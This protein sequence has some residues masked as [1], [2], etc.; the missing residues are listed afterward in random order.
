[1]TTSNTAGRSIL[2]RTLSLLGKWT[3][4]YWFA[5]LVHS[6]NISVCFNLILA[7]LMK[8]ALD[9]AQTGDIAFL[10]HS[11]LLAGITFVGGTPLLMFTN[12]TGARSLL[13]TLTALR[14][15]LFR[16]TMHLPVAQV[17]RQHSGDLISRFSNDLDTLEGLFRNGIS[18]LSM[19]IVIGTIGTVMVFSL[20]WRLGL[21]SLIL[22]ALTTLNS[23][24]FTRPLRERTDQIQAVLGKLTE[25][26]SD[27]I[28]SLTVTKLFQLETIILQQYRQTNHAFVESELAQARLD[29]LHQASLKLLTWLRR[30]GTLA[31][32]LVMISMDQ[33]ELG[34]LWAIIHLQG[35]ASFMFSNIGQFLTGIQRSLSG[36]TRLFDLLD[37]PVELDPPDALPLLPARSSE[38]ALQ[39]E[40]LCFEYGAHS[41]N[42]NTLTLD[43]LSFT[44]SAGDMVALVGPSGGGKS[45]LL[46]ILMGFYPFDQ[47]SILLN[48]LPLQQ[49]TRAELRNQLAYVPQNAYLFDDTIL[50]NIRYGKLDASDE[51]VFEAARRAYAHNFIIEQE[52]GYQTRVGE[53][54]A[55]L[56]GGQRQRIAIARALLKDAPILLLDEATSA[57]DSES[58]EL[59]QQALNQLMKGRTSLTIAH[60]LST[61]VR[62]DH[63]FVIDKGTLV[64]HGRHTELLEMGGLYARL[65]QLQFKQQNN[66]PTSS[67]STP[68]AS[69]RIQSGS[70]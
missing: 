50:E 38:A 54:G 13:K 28:Q 42:A 4:P 1:M 17:S 70:A 35:N 61:I 8:G 65:F 58:E 37:R 53:H 59:V 22:G 46:K 14:L 20:D 15:R 68:E 31:I 48:G 12:F 9:A 51:D 6:F 62:A 64:E 49:L 10:L 29:S 39:V 43:H 26:T 47:G 56:S 3:V 24:L 66:R 32:G 18:A 21:G 40:G 33:L 5:I 16:H 19:G 57:L 67:K 60:R 30:I 34:A 69:S 23:S 2:P 45:T 27:I 55:K 41:G 25:R 44:V 11:A 36:A 52:Q 63:I 7:Y